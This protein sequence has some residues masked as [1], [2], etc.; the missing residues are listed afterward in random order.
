MTA[1][2]T[3]TC[4]CGQLSLTCT[5]DPM[6]ISAC[7][8]LDCKRRSGSAFA[9]QARFAPETVT[10]TGTSKQWTR[11]SDAGNEAVFHFCPDC[12]TTVWYHALPHRALFAVPI[13]T[14]ADPAFPAPVY[15]VY[16]QRKH[17]WVEI[18]G[19]ATEHYE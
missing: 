15:S 8:C 4:P 16:E 5:G 10:V 19:D 1:I 12:G 9:V 7:H 11:I 17:A 18:I 2:R 14:F 6:R 3:A 13:G